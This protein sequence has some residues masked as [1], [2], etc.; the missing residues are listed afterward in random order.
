MGSASRFMMRTRG[1]NGTEADTTYHKHV[2]F[3]F[4]FF[5]L[6]CLSTIFS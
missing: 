5:F 3:S 1:A 6:Y 2:Q 4:F